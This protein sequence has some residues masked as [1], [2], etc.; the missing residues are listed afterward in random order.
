MKV[1]NMKT[2]FKIID[3]TDYQGECKK[4]KKKM[5]TK[6]RYNVQFRD[7]DTWIDCEDENGAL[8]FKSEKKANE[9]IRDKEEMYPITDFRIVY[10]DQVETINK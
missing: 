9:Y 6:K 2:N 4:G 5:N 3:G 8:I 1:Q 10:A 7:Y